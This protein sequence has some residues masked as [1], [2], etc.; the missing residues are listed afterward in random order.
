MLTK[1][2]RELERQAQV[3]GH[4]GQIIA[5][6]E[7]TDKF[8]T[9][10]TK[11]VISPASIQRA[12][13]KFSSM[14]PDCYV[15]VTAKSGEQVMLTPENMR[16]DEYKMATGHLDLEDFMAKWMPSKRK[17]NPKLIQKELEAEFKAEDDLDQDPYEND[18]PYE[19][20]NGDD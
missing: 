16:K 5:T 3:L 2:A 19:D 10:V 14:N 18:K 13:D 9:L 7:I 17:V 8:G 12:A 1:H 15:K 6:V 20:C 4:T 11:K